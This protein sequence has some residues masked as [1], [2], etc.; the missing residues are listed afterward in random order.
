M[1]FIAVYIDLWSIIPLVILF[2]TNLCICGVFFIRS[3]ADQ[4]EDT[5]AEEDN[6]GLESSVAATSP[7]YETDSIGWNR[8][9]VIMSPRKEHPDSDDSREEA[10][11]PDM[12]DEENTPIFLN[13]AAGIFFPICHTEAATCHQATGDHLRQLLAWQNKFLQVHILVFNTIILAVV[14][15]VYILVSS[16]PSFNYNYNVLDY[17][18][19]KTGSVFLGLMGV[20]S[21]VMSLEMDLSSMISRTLHMLGRRRQRREPGEDICRKFYLC[22][23]ATLL[24][25]L[26]AILAVVV[27]HMNPA[28][29]PLLLVAREGEGRRT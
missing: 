5:P 22:L 8:N 27:F 10:S 14:S 25:F 13:A 9:I 21:L 29:R 12:V 26:P 7:D 3:S 18:W 1:A 19:F 17:F 16:V 11:T 24:V 15:A 20:M 23:L 2:T 6:Q 4:A 28:P